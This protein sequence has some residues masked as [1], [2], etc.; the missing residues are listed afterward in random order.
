MLDVRYSHLFF[1]SKFKRGLSAIAELLVYHMKDGS[2]SLSDKKN[3][4]WGT[5]L[6]IPEI[7]DQTDPPLTKTPIQSI[8]AR[9]ASA[10]I[11][12]EKQFFL[13]SIRRALTDLVIGSPLRVYH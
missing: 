13:S 12:S 11:P 9:T 6:S 3:V 8:F 5:S 7:L 4:W 10:V 2:S 1:L